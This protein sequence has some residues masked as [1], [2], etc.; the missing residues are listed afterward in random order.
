MVVQKNEVCEVGLQRVLGI[1]SYRTVW[2]WLHKF[3]WFMVFPWRG[4]LTCNAKVDETFVGGKKSGK[5]G[6]GAQGKAL[7]VIAVGI[8]EK[9]SERVRLSIVPDASHESLVKYISD[10]LEKGSVVITNGWNGYSGLS[11]KG[12]SH[13]I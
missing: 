10:K 12:Y 1:G 2:T 6:R 13:K 11:A 5:R 3:R 7:V 8:L 4:R 9:G